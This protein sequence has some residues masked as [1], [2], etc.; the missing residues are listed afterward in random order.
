MR[1]PP[2]ARLRARASGDIQ[3]QKQSGSAGVKETMQCVY[4][5]KDIIFSLL[6]CVTRQVQAR[7]GEHHP[8]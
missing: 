7:L 2:P 3:G 1:L 8:K 4:N 5:L 6:H